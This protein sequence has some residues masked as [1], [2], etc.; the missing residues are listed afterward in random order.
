MGTR[1]MHIAE[2]GKSES[3]FIGNLSTQI[4]QKPPKIDEHIM[5]Q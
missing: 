5:F 2:A 1:L 4:S 3:C